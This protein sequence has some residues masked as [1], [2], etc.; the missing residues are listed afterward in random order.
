MF[1]FSKKTK[2]NI[3]FEKS[4]PSLSTVA[5]GQPVADP[6]EVSE[7]ID[8]LSREIKKIESITGPSLRTRR[9]RN[10]IAAL[11]QYTSRY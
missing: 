1:G 2:T 11:R 6:F 10:E 5:T 7:R 9:F 8:Y 3:S 4:V